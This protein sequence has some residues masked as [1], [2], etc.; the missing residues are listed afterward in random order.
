MILFMRREDQY[1][2]GSPRSARS[3]MSST[4]QDVQRREGSSQDM[5]CISPWGAPLA[6]E[7]SATVGVHLIWTLAFSLKLAPTTSGAGLLAGTRKRG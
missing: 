6:R 1:S 7:W 5:P 3:E 4:M 2:Q